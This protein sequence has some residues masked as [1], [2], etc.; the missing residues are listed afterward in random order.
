M[1]IAASFSP[2]PIGNEG[3]DQEFV[4]TAYRGFA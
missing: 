2:F 1:L 3:P 4:A